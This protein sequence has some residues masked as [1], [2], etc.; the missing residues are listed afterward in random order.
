LL[1]HAE[2][3]LIGV[4]IAH[5]AGCVDDEGDVR[6]VGGQ[7]D[8]R[9]V[10]VLKALNEAGG[11]G[12]GLLAGV[13]VG[14]FAVEFLLEVGKRGLQCLNERLYALPLLLGL[15]AVYGGFE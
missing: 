4:L 14:L 15:F 10:L 13:E 9:E 12:G 6:G 1:N 2:V 11:F 3:E 8:G 5:T 7:T